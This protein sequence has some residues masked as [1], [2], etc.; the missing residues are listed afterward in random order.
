MKLTALL[1]SV[2]FAAALPDLAAVRQKYINASKSEQAFEQFYK[3]VEHIDNSSKDFTMVAYK[4][5]AIMLKA[6]YT[7]G[8]FAKKNLFEEGAKL[9]DATIAKDTDNYEARLLRLNIQENV[10]RIT[11]Y[12]DN[13][14]EDK[15][16]LIKHYNNQPADLKEYT[17]NYVMVSSAFSKEEKAS[18]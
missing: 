1:L 14:N 15:N 18:F 10:P 17:K 13:I 5:T 2:L 6:R 12:K 7:K 4:A 9:M 11:G 3:T 16:F 8:L